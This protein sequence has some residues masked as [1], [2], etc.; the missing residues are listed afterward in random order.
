MDEVVNN[1]VCEDV[2]QKRDVKAQDIYKLLKK[3]YDDV[4]Q[5]LCAGEVSNSTGYNACRRL[6]FVAVNCYD[7][8]GY[9]IHAFEIKISKSDLRRELEDPTKH[10]IFFEELD[11]YSIIA[12]DYVL[13]AEY[14]ALIPPKWGIYVV[15]MRNVKDEISGETHGERYIK[16][17]RKP[18]YLHDEKDTMKRSFAMSLLRAIR[19]QNAEK[20]YLH[21]LLENEYK[22]GREE[23][24]H[25]FSWEFQ[26]L[27]RRYEKDKWKFNF[28]DK[29]RIYSKENA[30]KALPKLWAMIRMFDNI[31]YL[32]NRVEDVN[33]AL[34][35][36]KEFKEAIS[37]IMDGTEL[38]EDE[39][40]KLL[41]RW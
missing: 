24:E 29:L 21:D 33:K 40:K 37:R 4:R 20:M 15:A 41:E 23:A 7:S 12:P 19:D 27:K 32:N 30:D 22:R 3:R 1:E 8:K 18:L 25:S 13:D 35:S 11:T 34:K 9:G 36:V 39:K 10:N 38:S 26:D 17:V 6:D 2:A 16:V 28:A 5:W 14:K 31:D